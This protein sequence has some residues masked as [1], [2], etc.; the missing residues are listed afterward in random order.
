MQIHLGEDGRFDVHSCALT[1]TVWTRNASGRL[2]T[3]KQWPPT[4]SRCRPSADA[5]R[6]ASRFELLRTPRDARHPARSRLSH[7]RVDPS[8]GT[9]KRWRNSCSPVTS[10]ND[11]VA[12][13]HPAL[14]DGARTGCRRG[15]T[16]IDWQRRRLSAD[17]IAG[18]V[19]SGLPSRVWARTCSSCSVTATD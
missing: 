12:W 15:C 4:H 5:G 18:I 9:E 7:H 1:D 6:P 3:L 11:A 2:I 17:R 14:L 10:V 19:L 13:A 16:T 8:S